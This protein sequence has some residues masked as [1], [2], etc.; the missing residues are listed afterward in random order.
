MDRPLISADNVSFAFPGKEPLFN[1]LTFA[2]NSHEKVLLRGANGSGKSTL[3]NLLAGILKPGSGSI[4]LQGEDPAASKPGLFREFVLC[5]QN[6]LDDL[7]GLV[8]GHDL[9]LWRQVWPERFAD[10][11]VAS[12]DEPLLRKLDTPYTRL[13]GGELRAFTLLWL[14][15]LM[16]RFWLLD[17]PTD[18]LDSSRKQRFTTLLKSKQGAGYLIVSH[19]PALDSAMFD[20]VLLLERGSLRELT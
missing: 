9:A 2:I 3:L 8:P 4:M 15:L 13:S 19:D 18:A 11:A 5:R 17:E 1:D 14:T 16:D 7:F 6:P 12:L 10:D 20:R